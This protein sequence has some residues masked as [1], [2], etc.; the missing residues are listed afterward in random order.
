LGGPPA[1]RKKVISKG[2]ASK[3]P[4]NDDDTPRI[5]GE[6]TLA[7][8]LAVEGASG[9]GSTTFRQYPKSALS[10]YEQALEAAGWKRG[11]DQD[12]D[13]KTLI[14]HQ[15]APESNGGPGR[16]LPKFISI[17]VIGDWIYLLVV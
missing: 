10:D 5:E 8:R 1:N 9:N 15:K 3:T 12:S 2:E 4:D 6:A 11:D 16:P 17:I 13:G 14:S 7:C